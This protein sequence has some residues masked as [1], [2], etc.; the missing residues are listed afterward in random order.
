MK[1]RIRQGAEWIAGREVWVVLALSP[2]LL[3]PAAVRPLTITALVLLPLLWP[4]RCL[5]GRPL[6]ARTPLNG[7]LL[8]LL[9]CLGPAVLVAPLPDL[10][11]PQATT[12]LLGMSLYLAIVNGDEHWRRPDLGGG[13]LTIA[14]VILALLALVGTNWGPAKIA[15]LSRIAERLPRLV[16]TSPD[17][18]VGGGFHPGEIGGMMAGLL[19]VVISFTM[20]SR[21]RG[22]QPLM[23]RWHAFAWGS[24][25][26]GLLMVFVLVLTQSRT[27]M[28]MLLL[29]A[30]VVI[31]MRWR[32]VGVVVLA[33]FIAAGILLVIG[34]FS[35]TLGDWLT[36]ADAATR[37]AGTEPDSWLQRTE[38]WR[39]ALYVMR[40]YPI[41]GAGPRS[42]GA[43]A[44]LNYGFDVIAPDY[45]LRNAHNL[46]LQAG[47]DL[48]LVG[49]MGFAWLTLVLLLLGWAVR[50]RRRSDQRTGL[51]GIWLGL[52]V[53][54]G[55]GVANAV[56]LA[57]RPAVVLWM[58]IG[59]LVAAW[60]G[61]SVAPESPEAGERRRGR[62]PV[63]VAVVILLVVAGILVE[64]SPLW[65]L[66]RG[67][68]LLDR[69]LLSD[70]LPAEANLRD[71]GLSRALT[72]IESASD[73]PGALRRRAL[74]YYEAGD[75]A[76]AILLFRQDEAGEEYLVS[77][78]RQLLAEGELAEAERFL[79]MAREV[80]PD[81][82]RLVCLTGDVYRLKDSFFDALGFY[83]EVPQRAESFGGRNIRLAE[84]YYQ[85]ARYE[86]QLGN[87]SAAAGWFGEAAS[88]D[89]AE[90][91]YQVEWGRALFR[92]TG[93]I[94]QAAAIVEAVLES[95]PD[96]AHVMIVL[97]DMYLEAE[98]PQR[99]LEW[100]ES[101]AGLAPSDP[102]AWL[103]LAKAYWALEQGDQA[104]G[105]LAEVLRLDP[106]NE[107]ALALQAA[108]ESQ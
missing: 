47:T 61:D 29:V 98:R 2:W 44:R 76:R 34:L 51:T 3:F 52:V 108:W 7:P 60:Q 50:R 11:I 102:E 12:F 69:V 37:L 32:P 62:W 92:S 31:G 80:A 53:W 73:L 106:A 42:F 49:F 6:S 30:A 10:A 64:G 1:D 86:E 90:L 96:A 56:S 41:V 103:R 24:G 65:S 94:N 79:Q 59:F 54:L 84:C 83:R 9:L 19:P 100:S 67:A 55:H 48:G 91:P 71:D 66:N 23:D 77:R 13:L 25:A 28:L 21:N 104:R 93:E 36:R 26:A 85:L 5:A 22:R 15:L 45:E 99:S 58:M 16:L 72:L 81:S 82:G 14:G 20:L 63:L 46:W 57:A 8:L 105:A 74:A 87:W 68:N 95:D 75:Q 33:L 70:A 35:G 88:L 27:S 38:I 4:V 40:D 18:A 89:P 17:P 39:N 97:A 78:G 43:V 101:A 107:A